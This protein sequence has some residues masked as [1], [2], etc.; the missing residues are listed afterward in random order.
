MP[1]QIPDEQIFAA[2]LDIVAARGIAGATT[3]QIA[4][5]AEINEVTLFR[6]FGSKAKLLEAALSAEVDRFDA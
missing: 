3:K 5:A 1:R 2:A 4:A 6:R